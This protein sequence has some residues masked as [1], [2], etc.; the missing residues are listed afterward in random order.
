MEEGYLK[1]DTCNRDNCQGI[2]DEHDSDGC[3]SCHINPP[4]S[5][6]ETSREYC[7]E[8]GWDGEQEQR[9]ANKVDMSNYYK[10]FGSK[11]MHDD[12]HEQERKRKE[13][14]D[15]F[16]LMYRGLKDVEKLIIMHASHTHF[17][18]I[19]KGVYPKGSETRDSLIEKI[20]G[21]FG[22]RFEHFNDFSFK[23][24]AYTD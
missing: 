24:I 13:F 7:P 12:Y 11:Q 6:C 16:D 18:M 21:T 8:C 17:S 10:G 5:W 2:I 4:C 3:C 1:G 15:D 19:V 9:E 14:K 20:K 22:G 23:Y